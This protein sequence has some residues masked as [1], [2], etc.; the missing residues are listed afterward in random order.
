MN[1]RQPPRRI[2]APGKVFRPDT[3]DAS[4]LPIFHQVE[5]LMVGEDVTFS[6]LKTVLTIF[7]RQMYGEKTRTR[8]RPSYFPFTEPSAEMEV[9]CVLC[10]GQGCGPCKGSGWLEI[11]GSGMVHPNVFREVGYDPDRVT[12]FAFGMGVERIAMLKYRIND[13]RLFVE[14]HPSFLKQF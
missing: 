7:A 6:H 8:F 2:I 4:H 14:N 9:T 12:G 10:E 13:I 11:L 3:V 5:G 1:A